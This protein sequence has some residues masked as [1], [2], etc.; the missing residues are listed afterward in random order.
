MA[1]K[2]IDAFNENFPYGILYLAWDGLRIARFRTDDEMNLTFDEL[3]TCYSFIKKIQI[4][5]YV[6]AGEPHE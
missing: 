4:M 3:R 1:Q 2:D 5:D 6:K